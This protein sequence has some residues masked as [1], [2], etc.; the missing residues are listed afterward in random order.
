MPLS[1]LSEVRD[2]LQIPEGDP[3][4]DAVLDAF[5]TAVEERILD[6]TRFTFTGGTQTEQQ[7]DVQLGVSRLMKKRPIVPLSGDPLK[8]VKLQARSLASSTLSDIVGDIRD[9]Y[10][11]RIMPLA[12]ELTPIFPP[13]GGLAPWFRWRQMIW[14]VVIFTYAVDPLGSATNPVP[15]SLNRA[16]VEWA[17][18]IYALP[19]AGRIRSFSAEAI[20]ETYTDWSIP[21]IVGMLLAPYTKSRKA[22]LIF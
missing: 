6:L 13:V 12:S 7:V 19:A 3:A 4:Q 15:R 5:R 2:R 22:G 20:S 10:E 1:A 14:P 21:P 16:A 11:G 17:A 18:S 8:T 9:A